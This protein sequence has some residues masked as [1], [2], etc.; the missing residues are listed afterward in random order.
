MNCTQNS[1]ATSRYSSSITKNANSSRE[2]AD[3]LMMLYNN[4]YEILFKIETVTY[5]E[6]SGKRHQS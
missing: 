4:R 3:K 2:F 5:G 1:F 6:C